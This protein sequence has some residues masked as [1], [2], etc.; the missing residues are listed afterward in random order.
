[1]IKLS[2]MTD[3]GVVAMSQLNQNRGRVTTAQELAEATGLPTPTASKLLKQLAKA[4]LLD[5]H[6]GVKGGYALTRGLA[7]ISAVEI[8]EALDGPVALT[9]CVEGAEEA[10]NVETL[11]PM[12]GGWDKVNTAIRTA[13]EEV[14][15]ADLCI[16]R[17]FPEPQSAPRSEPTRNTPIQ[18]GI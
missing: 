6:R 16:P 12:R 11:C 3:Y 2:R 4:K 14:S 9:A 13:L 18:R 8:I 7:E 10:C 17:E 5:S 1:M 15:L